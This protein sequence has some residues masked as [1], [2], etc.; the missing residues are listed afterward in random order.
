MQKDPR[1]LRTLAA[2]ALLLSIGGVA[3]ARSKKADKLLAEGQKAEQRQEWDKALEF[4]EKALAEDPGEVKY[5]IATRRVRFRAAQAHVDLGQKLRSKGELEQA[6]AEFQKAFSMDPSSAIA[7]QELR[8]TLEMIE[9]AKKGAQA[10]PEER[11]LTPAEQARKVEQEKLARVRQPAELR[12]LSRQPIN[13]RMTNQPARVLYETVG[14]LAGINVVFDPDYAAQDVNA[15]RPLSIE[16]NNATLEEALDYLSTMTKTFWKPLSANA[17]FVTADNQAKRRDFEDSVVKVFYLRNLTTPQELTELTTTFR[18]VAEIRK[19]FQY[20][21]LNAII[22]R[23]S[24][25]QVLLAEKLVNDLDKPRSEVVVDVLVMEASR[26]KTRDLAAT[27]TSAAG[28]AGLSAP[29]TF[30]PRN[31]VL[32]GGQ[33]NNDGDDDSDDNSDS[34]NNNN[35]NNNNTTNQPTYNPYNPYNPY[36]GVNPY[37]SFGGGFGTFGTSTPTQQLISLARISKISTNDFSITLPGALLQA[38]SSDSNT[39]ILQSPQVRAA[40]GQKAVLHIGDRVPVASGGI[41]P[42]GGAGVGGFGSLYNQF[43]FVDVGVKVDVTPTV[44]GEEEVTLKVVLE[45]S[46]VRDRVDIGGIS[47]PIIGQR[48][49]EHEIRIKEGEASLLGGLMQ[50]QDIKALSGV[51]GLMNVPI[52]KRLFSSESL[53]KNQS[54]LL[55]ALIPH[56]VRTPGITDVNLKSVAAGSDQF[57][58]LSLAPRPDGTPV[59]EAKPQTAIPGTTPPPAGTPPPAAQPAPPQPAPAKPAPA[60]AQPA[61][62]ARIFFRPDTAEVQAGSTFTLQLEVENARDLFAAPFHLKFDPQVVRLNEVRPGGLLS[63][64]G[65]SVIFTRNILND[66]GDATVN[67]NRTPG[68][69]GVS[70][71]GTLAVFTFQ[72]VKAGSVTVTF[73]ELSARTS[74]MQPLEVGLPRATVTVR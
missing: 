5:Q 33:D 52:L 24:P 1:I 7:E 3:E 60:P 43:N 74:Q 56:I 44:H 49:V 34:N 64:D 9:R 29:I 67:L 68:T 41:Q 58:R 51:P 53:Q 20:N 37:G 23:G 11:G 8:R 50:D 4:Y 6:L 26:A 71:S 16:L 30:S 31:P 59:P 38:V 61:A 62:A 15:R 27:I 47:Q 39:R 45:I 65:Q 55:I 19:V 73:S 28:G 17:I 32:L 57:V 2:A 63:G 18:T 66:T 42:F 14:K 72:A 12:P 25:D 10:A 48:K 70:G 54:E 21:S 69:G 35:N 40:S 46:S 36:G 13:L 22:V